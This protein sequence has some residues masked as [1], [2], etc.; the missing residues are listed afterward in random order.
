MNAAAALE[1]LMNRYNENRAKAES[2]LG[3][4]F[5]ESEFNAWFTAQV[6]KS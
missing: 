1:E 2:E 4:A 5:N 6:I 3:S